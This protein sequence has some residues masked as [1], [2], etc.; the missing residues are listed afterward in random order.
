MDPTGRTMGGGIY[1][2][3]SNPVMVSNIIKNNGVGWGI[4]TGGGGIAILYESKPYILN[5]IIVDNYAG[6]GGGIHSRESE[7]VIRGNI[8]ESN[9]S[10]DDGG[11]IAMWWST[12]IIE[13]NLI[14][15]NLTG[16]VIRGWGGGIYI[17]DANT[18]LIRNN[19][20]YDNWAELGGGGIYVD[21]GI[22]IVIANN[23]FVLNEPYGISAPMASVILLY[24]NLWANIPDD[25]SPGEF[26]ISED[27]LFVDAGNDDFHLL[28][29]SPCIDAGNPETPN[30]PWGGFR[31]D[32]GAYEYD[33][34]FYF[35]GRNLIRKPV[36]IEYTIV[37]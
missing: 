21:G 23:I 14:I 36:P 35:D 26:D 15:H 17:L 33:Q 6:M 34:G 2:H 3:E 4:P 25:Y 24:N 37:R 19:T 13:Q 7:G 10:Y 11:G 30:I 31:R 5:N 27:P 28:P 29:D 20:F 16:D 1:I 8:I 32:M 18:S 22:S 12:L 9:S